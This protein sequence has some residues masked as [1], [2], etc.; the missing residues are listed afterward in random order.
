VII[1]CDKEL[2][3]DNAAA[4]APKTANPEAARTVTKPCIL[5]LRW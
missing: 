5:T 3:V 1:G 4:E 2:G